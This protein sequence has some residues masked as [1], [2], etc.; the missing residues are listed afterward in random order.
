MKGNPRSS[1]FERVANDWYA[2]SPE[3]VKALLEMESFPEPV[4][5]PAAGGG[6]IPRALLD[7]GYTQVVA[8]DKVARGCGLTMD[9]LSCREPLFE[10]LSI[11][12]NPPFSLA[13]EFV[14]HGLTLVEKVAVLQRTVWL[15][16]E[17]RYQSLF[18]KGHLARVWQF[19]SRVSMPPGGS[20]TPAQN[21]SVAY[22]WFLFDRTH[23]GPFEGGWLP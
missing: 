10:A 13:A 3:N 12:S 17:R 5:D 23:S 6:N 22:A 21:G 2:E 1:G 19:R 8:S 20:E 4:W 9:F 14:I 7:V 18:S 16:G 11:V 15:E